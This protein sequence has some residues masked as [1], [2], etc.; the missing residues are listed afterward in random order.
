MS[1]Y[2]RA[3]S[4]LRDVQVQRLNGMEAHSLAVGHG[5]SGTWYNTV[6]TPVLTSIAARQG[7]DLNTYLSALGKA[8]FLQIVDQLRAEFK[9]DSPG[10][11]DKAA[12]AFGGQTFMES[13]KYPGMKRL[14]GTNL[15]VKAEELKDGKPSDELTAF[16]KDYQAGQLEWYRGVG[17]SHFAWS[18]L[19]LQGVLASEGTADTPTFTMGNAVATRWLPGV[20]DRGT[21]AIVAQRVDPNDAGLRDLITA[22]TAFPTG[23]ILKYK[24]P[25]TAP[26]AYLNAGEQVVR[27]PTAPGAVTVDAVMVLGATG[28]T[29][30]A[31]NS[32]PTDLPPRAPYQAQTADAAFQQWLPRAT[33]WVATH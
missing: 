17:I 1:Q 32:T 9:Q 27:G 19:E 33:N 30:K 8:Q 6:L 16:I 15:L 22:N 25:A 20:N 12:A 23:A 26:V 24:L 14:V 2:L 28:F 10:W 29:E 11:K 3:A 31:R 18:A 7:Q 21:A 5:V 4:S 13:T